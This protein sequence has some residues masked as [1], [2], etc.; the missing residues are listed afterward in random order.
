[1]KVWWLFGSFSLQVPLLLC[2]VQGYAQVEGV[3][4]DVLV[5]RRQFP[6][7]FWQRTIHVPASIT[8]TTLLVRFF[9]I[10]FAWLVL[11]AGLERWIKLRMTC[12]HKIS[13]DHWFE[14]EDASDDSSNSSSHSS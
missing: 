3:P 6:N 7:Q 8:M 9:C 10:V 13:N 11:S 14:D 4:L 1:M 12:Q 2:Y 5:N